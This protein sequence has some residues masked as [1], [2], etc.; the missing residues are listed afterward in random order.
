MDADSECFGT[1]WKD[2]VTGSLLR[3][4]GAGFFI[5]P[6]GEVSISSIFQNPVF[7]V[8]FA[9]FC[10]QFNRRFWLLKKIE[11]ASCSPWSGFE[12]RPLFYS[13]RSGYYIVSQTENLRG[14]SATLPRPFGR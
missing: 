10:G 13:N 11:A 1:A 2:M 4:Y 3:Q 12:A 6:A 5:H 9:F 8:Y 14:K 7:F